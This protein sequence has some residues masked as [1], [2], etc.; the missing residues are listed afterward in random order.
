MLGF[1]GEYA[2]DNPEAKFWRPLVKKKRLHK[3][4]YFA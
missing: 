1:N 4:T 2:A 3:K